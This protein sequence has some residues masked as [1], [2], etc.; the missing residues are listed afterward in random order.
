MNF[1]KEI[2]TRLEPRQPRKQLSTFSHDTIV[3]RTGRTLFRVCQAPCRLR[4]R[5]HAVHVLAVYFE[6]FLASH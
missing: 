1:M 4:R 2:R 6:K 3:A 5:Q